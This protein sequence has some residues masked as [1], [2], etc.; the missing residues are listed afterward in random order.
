VREG[1][2]KEGTWLVRKD[3]ENVSKICCG[4][5]FGTLGGRSLKKG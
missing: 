3:V 5:S 4:S 2:G 1:K